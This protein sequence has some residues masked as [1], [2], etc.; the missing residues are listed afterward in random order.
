MELL[1]DSHF[2]G[3]NTEALVHSAQ[4]PHGLCPEST[5][6]LGLLRTGAQKSPSIQFLTATLARSL[7]WTIGGH[8]PVK[9][10]ETHGQSMGPYCD[11]WL[12]SKFS[13]LPGTTAF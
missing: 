12:K 7:F 13:S 1:F 10:R 4:G 5:I 3:K 8:S 2:T 11:T 9:G 6:T